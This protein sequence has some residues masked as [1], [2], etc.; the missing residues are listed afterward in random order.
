M[1]II[2]SDHYKKFLEENDIIINYEHDY[3]EEE[4]EELL[5][6]LYFNEVS[7]VE[8]DNHKAAIFAKIAD[9]VYNLGENL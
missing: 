8:Y 1:K 7:N 5:D 3:S 2:L 6:E 9:A 4:Y